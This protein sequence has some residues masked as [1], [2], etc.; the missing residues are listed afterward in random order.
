MTE[1]PTAAEVEALRDIDTPTICNLLEMVVPER[2][3]YGYTVEHLHCLYP[4]MKPIVG[5]A[6]TATMRA[7]NP[8]RWSPA[9][10]MDIRAGYFDYL[11]E[12]EAPKISVVQD[13]DERPG[14]GAFY[15]EVFSAVHKALGCRGVVTNGSV[16]DIDM[17]APDFQVLAGLIA[18]S[19]AFV[20]VAQWGCEVNVHGMVVQNGDLIH[21]DRHGA[22]VVPA[23]G[24][25]RRAR[26]AR[27]HG[28]PRSGHPGGGAPPRCHGGGDQGRLATLDGDQG[29]VAAVRRARRV[30][31]G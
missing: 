12:G 7:K 24:G 26:Q 29:I 1:I 10:Y 22:V 9:E 28:A 8:A 19:H 14:Y 15:G 18:P 2:R 17:L 3:G 13:T 11:A 4:A 5:F 20:H 27:S 6:K 21:A 31:A 23:R 25:A 16:R 30:T